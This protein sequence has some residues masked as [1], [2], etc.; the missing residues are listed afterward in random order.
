MPSP[1]EQ[2]PEAGELAATLRDLR[3]SAGLSGVEV[4]RR[5]GKSQAWVSRFEN[6][7]AVPTPADVETLMAIY[8]ASVRVRRRLVRLSRDLREDTAPP[9]RV[10]MQRAGRMQQRVGRIEAQ[11]VR[12]AHFH[13]SIVAG[14]LQSEDYA[15]TVFASGADLP[16]DQQVEALAGR[17]ERHR[18]LHEPGREFVFVMTEGVLRWPLGG[19][20]VMAAQIDHVIETS[21]LPAVRVGVVP[22]TTPV[23]VAPV[24]GFSL[25]DQRAVVVGT[26]TATAFLTDPHDVGMYVK[27]FAEIESVATFGDEARALLG[28]FAADYRSLA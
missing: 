3:R 6:G 16:P 26:E 23:A 4:G 5:A 9:A 21:R 2:P 8:G 11:S 20:G 10:V 24:N 27:L 1:A 22:W 18:I 12:I 14:L 15:R 19:P 17:M 7:A 25:Y 28:L 13:T